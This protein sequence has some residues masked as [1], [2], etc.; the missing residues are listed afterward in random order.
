[1]VRL[2]VEELQRADLIRPGEIAG[3]VDDRGY[4]CGWC[5]IHVDVEEYT[6]SR[7]DH[8]DFI[9]LGQ[10]PQCRRIMI[11]SFENVERS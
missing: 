3:E 7:G 5:N 4:I 6:N 2:F 1:M 8:S 9:R 11:R 10:C